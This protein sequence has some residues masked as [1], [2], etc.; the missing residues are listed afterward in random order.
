MPAENPIFVL[1][2]T[3]RNLIP[4]LLL[5][6]A[7]LFSHSARAEANIVHKA[8][9]EKA[10]TIGVL[11]HRGSAEAFK[12]WTPLAN[13]LTGKVRDYHFH[14]MPLNIAETREAVAKQ[15]IDFLL[16]NPGNFIDLENRFNVRSLATMKKQYDGHD[17]HAFGAVI[18]TR[19]DR[20][21]INSLADLKSRS[22]MG[23]KPGAFGG[24][25]LAWREFKN[26]SIDPFTEFGELQFSGFPQSAVVVAVRN[27]LVDAGTVR[28]GILEAMAD[29]GLVDLKEFRILN[30][31]SRPDFPFM[32]STELYPEWPIAYLTNT[33]QNLV[34]TVSQTLLEMPDDI[35]RSGRIRI[36]G[37]KPSSDYQPVHALMQQLQVGAYKDAPVFA[38]NLFVKNYLIWILLLSAMLVLMVLFMLHTV[39]LNRRI[40]T[41]KQDLERKVQESA[42]LER[43]LQS[44]RNLLHTLLDNISDGVVAC[45]KE[46]KITHFNQ[47]MRTICG[48]GATD[49][50]GKQWPELFDIFKGDG[51]TPLCFDDSP[52]AQVLNGQA[53]MDNEMVI[54]REDGY[55]H[56]LVSGQAIVNNN[57]TDVGAVL[58]L[59]DITERIVNEQKLRKSEREL[60]AILDSM[61]DTYYRTNADG[62][63]VSVSKSITNMLGY[64]PENGVG[65][66]LA[67]LYVEPGGREKFLQ[68]LRENGGEVQNYQSA[69]WHKQGHVIWVSTSAHFHYDKDGNIDGVEGVTRDITELKNAE[70]QL[71]KE[72]ERAHI[73]LQSIGDGVVTMD[74]EGNI[75][76]LNPYAEQMVGCSSDSAIKRQL[77]SLLHFSDAA[78]QVPLENP[79]SM[80]LEEEQVF[81]YNEHVHATRSDGT[82]FAVKLTVSPMRDPQGSIQGVVMVMHDVSEMWK[83]AQQLSYQAS[84][85][86]LT[87]LINRREFDRQL[88][89]ALERCRKT[90]RQHTL[91][92][93][94]LDQFKIVND[95]CG[96]IAGDRLLKQLSQVLVSDVR[97]NDIFARLGGD[98]FG[99]LLEGCS[100]DKAETIVEKIRKTVK[101]FRFTWEDKTFELGVSIGM[102]PI[103]KDSASVTELLSEADAACYVAKD[104]GRNRIHKY[105]HGDTDLVKHKSE[106]QWVNRIQQALKEDRFVSYCQSMQP[107]QCE[108]EPYAEILIR[109]LDENGDIVLPGAFI[110]AA[111]RYH[112]MTD[113]DRWVIRDVFSW[114]HGLT[115][116]EQQHYTINLSGQ[117]VGDDKMLQFIIDCMH[118]YGIDPS[119][120]CFEITETA[121]VA[122]LDSARI[123][124]AH[125]HELGCKFALDDFG[126]GLSSFAYLKNL[127]VD[128]LKIDG[129]FVHNI[130]NDPV[131]YAMVASIN[132]IGHLMGIKTIAEFVEDREVLE[133]LKEIGIDYVQGYNIDMPRSL[134][135]VA[136]GE[137]ARG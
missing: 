130:D 70:A 25:Q 18:F 78:T 101:G 19:A 119:L 96:H 132:R 16:T 89:Q 129:S 26:N 51:H 102:V 44:E 24:F 36:T 123:F 76:Y 80:C 95:T 106:M 121:A 77:S 21:D 32:L 127:D 131:D 71:F 117:S 12:T 92:Y 74:V 56:L 87:G 98:E 100:L 62:M 105:Q 103:D 64:T 124:I 2:R 81:V 46:G 7:S 33:S 11:A 49:I 37:W 75:E 85:D 58:S 88:S 29:K 112:L 50:K 133:R 28:T 137:I 13:Y 55:R 39:F 118:E 86:A 97:D 84:H 115:G 110:P 120:I 45:N 79:V 47:A 6:L 107:L 5:L 41:G 83:M 82:R 109:M 40:L 68:A 116:A 99:L 4:I 63:V 1:L 104:L 73:T 67:G 108:D 15:K 91:C 61:Q 72:K 94:D 126:S 43:S 8:D 60:R 125:L 48:L 66:D 3:C 122:N 69:M 54:K 30:A 17:L 136:S 135:E 9:D 114:L 134:S 57:S 20:L 14:I 59:H 42:I 53:I 38:F 23:V 113:I 90:D 27:G 52:F 65:V 10:V 22:F 111:E 93:M 35:I 34:N 31:Q 128:F